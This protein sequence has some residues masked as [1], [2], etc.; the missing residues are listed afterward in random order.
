M[1]NI[2]TLNNFLTT[3]IVALCFLDIVYNYIVN[4]Y[5]RGLSFKSFITSAK[6]RNPKYHSI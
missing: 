1:R 3:T 5:I 2:R 6:F 4:L